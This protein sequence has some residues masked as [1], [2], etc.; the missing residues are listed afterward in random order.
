MVSQISQPWQ[1]G[2]VAIL[3]GNPRY[4]EAKNHP[5]K[6]PHMAYCAWVADNAIY[7]LLLGSNK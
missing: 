7:N 2:K 3:S 1:H 6:Q 5:D 4:S